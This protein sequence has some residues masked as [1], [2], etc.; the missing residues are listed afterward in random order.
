[1]LRRVDALIPPFLK[2][3]DHYLL[4]HYPNLWAT[5]AHYVFFWGGTLLLLANARIWTMPLALDDM[6]N[7]ELLAGLTL[8]PAMLMFVL[9]AWRAN[10]FNVEAQFGKISPRTELATQAVYITGTLLLAALPFFTLFSLATRIDHRVSPEQLVAD[11]NTLNLGDRYFATDEYDLENSHIDSMISN[12]FSV[13]L[14]DE[15]FSGSSLANEDYSMMKK[16]ASKAERIAAIEQYL[17][18][19]NQYS[20]IN[21]TASVEG[22]EANFRKRTYP[23]IDSYALSQ[24][25]YSA[26][27]NIH[28]IESANSA[29][30]SFR[31]NTEE[32]YV[33]FYLTL[34][35]ALALN[36]FVKSSLMTFFLSALTSGAL[37]AG[38]GIVGAVIDEVGG[39]SS[40]D[41][42]YVLT[43][44]SV[45]VFGIMLVQAFRTR[46]TQR[47]Q[48][49]KQIALTSVSLGTAVLPFF[50][51]FLRNVRVSVDF[52]SNF[53]LF[54]LLLSSSVAVSYAAWY[55][56]YRP[57][58]TA[59][60]A[61]PSDN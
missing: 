47:L 34:L 36:V 48:Q 1:M 56:V 12:K 9:W 25:K 22:I 14:Y 40:S 10:V 17:T 21:I 35:L 5:R 53:Q 32:P 8:I 33:Y 13:Y 19:L 31:W 18:V 24:A 50:F 4:L 29:L 16:P 49:W 45:S 26:M 41:M 37:I 59:L 61:Q 43:F 54:L 11:V 7:T 3:I 27:E 30:H 60:Q 57:R 6:P 20:D 28:L 52:M 55:W 15:N 39:A 44:L 23:P 2:K 51:A 42:E 46:H 58:F 38:I